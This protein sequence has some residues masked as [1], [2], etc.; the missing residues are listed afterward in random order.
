MKAKVIALITAL[1]TSGCGGLIRQQAI[2][3]ASRDHGCPTTQIAITNDATIGYDHAY[4]MNVCGQF[5]YYRYVQ[6]QQLSGRFV[7]DTKRFS[8]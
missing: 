1:V 4:W 2:E 7:D 5:R 3:T 8:P 6:T